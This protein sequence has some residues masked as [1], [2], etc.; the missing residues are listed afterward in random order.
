MWEF[1]TR[2]RRRFRKSLD[3]TGWEK[4]EVI[5]RELYQNELPDLPTEQDPV[6]FLFFWKLTI[7]LSR[8]LR[9]RSSLKRYFVSRNSGILREM[10][11]QRF[12]FRRLFS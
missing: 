12:H 2:Y 7:F 8:N 6:F 11:Q 10:V 9:Q 1:G 5:T 4:G 3:T